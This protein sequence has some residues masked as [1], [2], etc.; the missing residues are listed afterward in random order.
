MHSLKKVYADLD[1]YPWVIDIPLIVSFNPSIKTATSVASI[2]L[3]LN[4]NNF[5]NFVTYPF[6]FQISLL[7]FLLEIFFFWH[8]I[9]H[10]V[11]L[12]IP[13]LWNIFIKVSCA[14]EIY[15]TVSSSVGLFQSD[16]LRMW[17]YCTYILKSHGDREFVLGW[18]I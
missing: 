11:T 17:S 9:T 2:N 16:T 4:I 8:S 14:I 1:N 13:A 15:L 6:G 18:V 5:Q 12:T 7:R 3:L 10:Y